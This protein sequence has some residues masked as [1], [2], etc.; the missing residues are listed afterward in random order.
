MPHYKGVNIIVETFG[1]FRRE[2]FPSRVVEPINVLTR[3]Y[4][5]INVLSSVSEYL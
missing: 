5:H 2:V 3:V 1:S 4:M